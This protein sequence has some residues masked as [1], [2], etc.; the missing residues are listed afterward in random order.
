MRPAL[1]MG[2]PGLAAPGAFIP[3]SVLSGSISGCVVVYFFASL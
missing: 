2:V 1:V 3:W